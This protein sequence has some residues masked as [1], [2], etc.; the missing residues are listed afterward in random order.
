[1]ILDNIRTAITQIISST[2]GVGKVIHGI[3]FLTSQIE[4]NQ[5]SKD[6]IIN[7]VGFI[8]TNK[9]PDIEEGFDLEDCTRRF[10]FVYYYEHRNQ[11]PQANVNS[12]KTVET[13]AE[14]LMNA[15][16]CNETLKGTVSSH[17]KLKLTSNNLITSF[18]NKLVHMLTFELETTEAYEQNNN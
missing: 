16:N 15:F 10:F 4:I 3:V 11:T 12:F 5:V 2:A 1:M 18:N 14:N 6:G 8:H 7:A 9:A 13:F 17:N